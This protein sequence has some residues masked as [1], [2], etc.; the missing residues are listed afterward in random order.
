MKKLLLLLATAIGAAA[1]QKKVKEQKA[2]NDLWQQA[3]DT[4]TKS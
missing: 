4:S 2:E 3:T 1:I